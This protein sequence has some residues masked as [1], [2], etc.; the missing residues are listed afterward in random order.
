MQPYSSDTLPC[1]ANVFHDMQQAE[2]YNNGVL[3]DRNTRWT[4][5]GWFATHI[6][7]SISEAIH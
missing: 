5:Q 2:E 6:G 1:Q 7:P 3:L 4:W